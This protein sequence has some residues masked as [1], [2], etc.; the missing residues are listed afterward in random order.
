MSVCH[1][2]GRVPRKPRT[3]IG[4]GVTGVCSDP[5]RTP[6]TKLWSSE[7]QQAFL[8]AEPSLLPLPYF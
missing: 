4:A 6:G 2:W 3:V 7:D 8:T 5:T 1:I